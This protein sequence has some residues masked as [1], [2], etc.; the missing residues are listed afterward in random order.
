MRLFVVECVLLLLW[1][2]GGGG[3][4]KKQLLLKN[5]GQKVLFST[6]C[7]DSGSPVHHAT[8]VRILSSVSHSPNLPESSFKDHYEVSSPAR[9]APALFF[10]FLSS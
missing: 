5:D 7:L 8:H 2:L 3:I 6:S 1:G 4:F 10:F 9:E